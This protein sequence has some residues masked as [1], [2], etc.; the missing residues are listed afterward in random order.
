MARQINLTKMGL[1]DEIREFTD[2]QFQEFHVETAKGILKAEQAKGTF[3]KDPRLYR[4]VIDSRN[5]DA[6]PEEVKPFGRIDFSKK[7]SIGEIV[8]FADKMIRKLSP[9]LKGQYIM[10]HLITID[11]NYM[12]RSKL[13]QGIR[14]KEGS[15]IR[16]INSAPYAR[17][18]EG[19]DISDPST[20]KRRKPQSMQAPNG[21][22]RVVFRQLK[23]R[24]GRSAFIDYGFV[25][26]INAPTVR[27]TRPRRPNS[28]NRAPQ[29]YPAITITPTS[30]TLR[31]KKGI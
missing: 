20:G 25:N 22:Y 17:K 6:R 13:R 5:F 19:G 16:F 10:S 24:F 12:P 28:P 21:V 9:I 1:I 2:D 11:G 23:K 7:A 31:G 4:T 29:R 18:I 30:G 27:V 15:K 8:L 3:P 14:I 26:L